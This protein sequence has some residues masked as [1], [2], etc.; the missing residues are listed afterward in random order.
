[1]SLPIG[2]ADLVMATR[3]QVLMIRE[4]LTF[5]KEWPRMVASIEFLLHWRGIIALEN[6]DWVL[7]Y[8]QLFH[9]YIQSGV[10]FEDLNTLNFSILKSEKTSREKSRL[11]LPQN[12]ILDD[13]DEDPEVIM[14][15]RKD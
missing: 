2:D 15:T 10:S 1:M 3:R 14:V 9:T 11:P 8:L 5:F 13:S 4:S 6:K 12:M 7:N